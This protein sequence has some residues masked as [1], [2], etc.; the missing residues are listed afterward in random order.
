M[1]MTEL[2]EAQCTVD[3][4]RQTLGQATSSVYMAYMRAR[5]V[6]DKAGIERMTAG[7]SGFMAATARIFQG[8]VVPEQTTVAA[9]EIAPEP[10]A[11]APSRVKTE[12]IRSPD[13][14]P[15]WATEGIE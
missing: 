5:Q 8:A 9:P 15:E 7:Q 12:T 14:P 6:L 11:P 10:I 3:R 4:Y 13:D 2:Q 1:A